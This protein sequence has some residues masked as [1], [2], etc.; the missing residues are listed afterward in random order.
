MIA[1]IGKLTV[2][3][4][5]EERA[6]YKLVRRDTMQDV[7]GLILSAN[8]ESGLCLMRIRDGESVEYNFGPDGLRIVP[9]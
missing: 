3:H 4:P 1:L 2:A 9:R 5:E 8:A 6:R 7:L